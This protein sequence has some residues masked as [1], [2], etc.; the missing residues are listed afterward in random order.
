MKIRKLLPYTL[1]V[2][3][4]LG[5]V[6]CSDSGS[7][8][9]G[10]DQ[11]PDIPAL[12]ANSQPDIS[13]FQ[14][15]NPTKAGLKGATNAT[16]QNFNTAKGT[17]L[18]GAAFLSISQAYT[19]FITPAA[20]EEADFVN[21][22]WVWEYSFAQGGQSAS[23]RTTA[24][25]QGNGFEWSVFVSSDDGEGNVFENF[26]IMEGTASN[27]GAQGNWTFF[28]FADED[29]S[30]SMP[31]LT[32]SWTVV[33]ETESSIELEIFDEGGE[34]TATITYQENGAENMMNINLSDEEGAVEVFWNTDTNVG[35]VVQDGER[36]CWDGSFQD[37][38]C[39]A[40]SW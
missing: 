9:G 15:N 30:N 28:F 4:A 13:F 2:F 3:L 29:Q 18:G 11:P 24:R 7:D 17:V 25:P 6:A 14:N 34:T 5:F 1:I 32:S 20:Q 23:I 40:V 8:S 21:G 36:V 12:T 16:V 10:E 39:S 31:F 38:S 27:D 33:S 35:Y 19:G 26:K 22:Q 37:V